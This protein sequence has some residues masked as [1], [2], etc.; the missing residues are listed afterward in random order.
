MTISDRMKRNLGYLIGLLCIIARVLTAVNYIDKLRIGSWV[1]VLAI[2]INALVAVCGVIFLKKNNLS[3]Q[4]TADKEW[5]GVKILV[6]IS[7]IL[8]HFLK[9]CLHVLKN[10]NLSWACAS[11]SLSLSY[12]FMSRWHMG[13]TIGISISEGS[14]P[15]CWLFPKSA[16]RL[17]FSCLNRSMSFWVCQPCPSPVEPTLVPLLLDCCS[18]SSLYDQTIST[19]FS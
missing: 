4:R 5:K 6:R 15:V 16:A 1:H 9:A 18:A 2:L 14:S 10:Y 12:P 8:S 17:S 13:P 3:V 11:L 7:F 19:F